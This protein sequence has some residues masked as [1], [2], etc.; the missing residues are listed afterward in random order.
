MSTPTEVA[1]QRYQNAT[2][3]GTK[4]SVSHLALSPDF[5]NFVNTWIPTPLSDVVVP[6]SVPPELE[7]SYR[8]ILAGTF[9]S[10]YMAGLISRGPSVQ[11]FDIVENAGTYTFRMI[12]M[13]SNS[14]D[15]VIHD[16]DLD[17]QPNGPVFRSQSGTEVMSFVRVAAPSGLQ[18]WRVDHIINNRVQMRLHFT[19]ISF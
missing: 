11:V 1:Y 2:T 14:D 17:M 8:E 10:V 5:T 18:V 13:T 7:I 4:L 16:A 19:D 3:Q 6:P 12:P 15:I 9:T